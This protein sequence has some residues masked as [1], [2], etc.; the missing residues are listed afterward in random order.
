MK[1]SNRLVLLIGIFLALI[2]FVLILVLAERRRRWRARSATAPTT[3]T[4]VVAAKD[5]DLGA[6]I[7]AEDVRED[8]IAITDF[9]RRRHQAEQ[10]RRSARSRASRSRPARPSPRR[11]S[12][13]SGGV[14][15]ELD[16]PPGHVAMAVQVD[17]V[18]GVGTIIKAGD[19]VD[20]VTGVTGTDKIPLV[21]SPTAR[22][23]AAATRRRHRA[24]SSP[25]SCPTT[26]RPSRR[27][28]R[29]SRCSARCSR[30]RPRRARAATPGAGRR[31]DDPQRPAADRDARAHAA[32]RR[33]RQV[34]PD[35]RQH[36]ARPAVH[37]GLQ[38]GRGAEPVAVAERQPVP[39]PAPCRCSPARPSRPRASRSAS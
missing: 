5:I 8:A 29:A 11:S 2:A 1:R 14:I 17:Q 27:S 35:G 3:T 32:G 21:V 33:G 6:T 4:I 20:V 30:R 23:G 25:R 9:P 19:Y 34:R 15:A 16:V 24:A 36:L 26:R 7:L 12:S 31:R 22:P 38:A 28:S 37:R 39:R 13:D 10:P 18:T